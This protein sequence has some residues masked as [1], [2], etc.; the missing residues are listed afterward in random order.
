MSSIASAPLNRPISET[1]LAMRH[2]QHIH[3]I[4]IGGAGMGGI[5]E[6]LLNQGY[7]VSGSDLQASA[8][9][10]RLASCGA[11]IYIGHAASHVE[12]ANVVVVST[13]VPADN[14]E[15]LAAHKLHI[16]VVP[17][18]EML[19]ELMRFRYGIAIAGTHGKTT[20]TSLVSSIFA[21]AGL[22]PTFVIGGRL[23]SAG[24]N[25][26]LGAGYYLIAEA[27]ES[28]ASFLYLQPMVAVVTNIDRDHMGTYA[29]D[30]SRLT[31]T[32]IDFL[33]RVPFYGVV[34][35]CLDDPVV[36]SIASNIHR[37]RITYGFHP[38]A[39]IHVVEYTQTQAQSHFKAVYPK[40]NKTYEFT[41]NL[42]GKHNVRNA[43]AAIA[44]AEGEGISADNMKNVFANFAGVGRRF[45]M[46]HNIRTQ[47]GEVM[48]IV[49]IKILRFLCKPFPFL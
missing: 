45:Q 18:A 19:A 34:I 10:E 20:T 24:T 12:K 27:D 14:V 25:A 46:T 32:F 43:L 17:R 42:P 29:D 40:L 30:F 1:V 2:I 26:K 41:L 5:A 15:V 22:D 9:T 6:V 16:P 7:T 13:A 38:D 28:D 21:Q 8:M 36:E 11:T 4:G 47:A 31:Q 39:D 44:V 49:F 33:H 48:L 35:L 37:P 3:F 23:N